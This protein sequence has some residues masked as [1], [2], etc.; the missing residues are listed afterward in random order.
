[1]G[2][3]GWFKEEVVVWN[4]APSSLFLAQQCGGFVHPL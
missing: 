1:M 3:T 2:V 4:A